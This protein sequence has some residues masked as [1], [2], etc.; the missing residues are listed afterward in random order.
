MVLGIFEES[1]KRKKDKCRFSGPAWQNT[2]KG[3]LFPQRRAG[4]GKQGKRKGEAQLS[5][6]GDRGNRSKKRSSLSR[7]IGIGIGKK[8]GGSAAF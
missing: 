4:L 1:K 6:C 5:E 2:E 8:G 7:G 3:V